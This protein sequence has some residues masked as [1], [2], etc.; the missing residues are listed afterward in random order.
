MF[1]NVF[2]VCYYGQH[3]YCFAYSQDN[4][5]WI[6]YDDKTVKVIGGWDEVLTM[7][8]RGHLQPQ[9]LFFEDVNVK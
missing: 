2:K 1:F 8:G 3:Y 7:C 4:G 9:V 6:M 5:R